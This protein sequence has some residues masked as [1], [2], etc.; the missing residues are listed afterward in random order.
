MNS[1]LEQSIAAEGAGD[2]RITDWAECIPDLFER[3]S[4]KFRARAV[5]ELSSQLALLVPYLEPCYRENLQSSLVQIC[6]T[7]G[8]PSESWKR[9]SEGFREVSGW[10]YRWRA[11]LDRIE[12]RP[13]LD[14][15]VSLLQ[16]LNRILFFTGFLG[17]EMTTRVAASSRAALHHSLRA[18]ADH[19]DRF[20]GDYEQL[21]NGLLGR[22]GRSDSGA[23]SL[24]ATFTRLGVLVANP[25]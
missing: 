16:E 4:P 7:H 5:R 10:F 11:R 24:G 9:V 17:T 6:A 14:E 13:K 18:A 2:R 8:E 23:R 19:Y 22:F 1:I 15:L 3:E 25:S 12:E 21:W 20:L